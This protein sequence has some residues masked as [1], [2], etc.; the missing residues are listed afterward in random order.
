LVHIAE[1]PTRLSGGINLPGK[2]IVE[3]MH[4]VSEAMVHETIKMKVFENRRL[5]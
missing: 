1:P 4:I 2:T 3:K 5:P